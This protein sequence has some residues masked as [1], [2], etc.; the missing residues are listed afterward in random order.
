MMIS[1]TAFSAMFALTSAARSADVAIVHAN[2]LPISGP[3]VADGTVLIEGGRI[4]AVGPGLAVPPGTPEVVDAAGGWLM[5]G[6]IDLHSH[7]GVY[8]WPGGESHSDGNEATAPT[9]PSVWAGDSVRVNDPAFR[10]AVAG[11]VTTVLVLP[12]SANL[13]GGEGV[14]LKL[15]PARTFADMRVA[16]APRHIKMACGENPKRVYH[17]DEDGPSTRMGNVAALRAR[18]Q[19][20]LDYRA[21]RSKPGSTTPTDRDLDVL[22]DVLDGKVR[23]NVHCYRSDDIEG[24]LRVMDDFGVQINAFHHATDA[25]KVRDLLAAHGVGIATW[26][27][28]WGF[29]HESFDAIPE[30]AAL[31]KAAGLRVATHSDSPDTVQRL[32]LEAAKHVGVGMSEQAAMETITLD[33]AALIGLAD[34]IGTIEIGKDAD[35]VLFNHHPFDVRALA[36]L[37]WIEGARVYDRAAAE[38]ADAQR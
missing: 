30:N 7:M 21:L 12:G 23:V 22:L 13:V 28:W 17:A 26:P 34:R 27:D 16:G 31:S 35:L 3:P 6:L 15:R 19:A 36:Q 11:G 18:L 25:Y 38:R 33:P 4:V 5:P 29:K 8:S 2:L 10:A 32:H 20:A 1:S 14:V 37:T 9:T 24:V